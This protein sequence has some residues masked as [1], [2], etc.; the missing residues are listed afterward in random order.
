LPRDIIDENEYKKFHIALDF[1]FRVRSALHLATKRKEDRLRLDLI[2][3][4]AKYLGYGDGYREHIKFAKL[5]G[6]QLKVI[7]LYTSIWIYNLTDRT[8]LPNRNIALEVDDKIA[9]KRL[10]PNFN[11]GFY[12]NFN[13]SHSSKKVGVWKPNSKPFLRAFIFCQRRTQK[14]PTRKGIIF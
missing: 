7:K 5:V 8:L 13:H 1:I 12:L 9:F 6:L 14:G 11:G 3:Q 2:P 4:I 10:L